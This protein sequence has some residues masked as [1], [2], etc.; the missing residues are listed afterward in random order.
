MKKVRNLDKIELIF[1]I[2]FI[3]Y[4]ILSSNN[5]TYG[6]NVISY[7]MW[8]MILLGCILLLYRIFNWKRY[9]KMPLLPIFVCFAGSFLLSMLINYQ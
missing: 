1:K 4:V 5:L 8:P 6:K 7:V 2:M 3:I 9:I